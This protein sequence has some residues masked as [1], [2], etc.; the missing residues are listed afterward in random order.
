M[1]AHYF[2]KL[3]YTIMAVSFIQQP[4]SIVSGFNEMN[5]VVSSTISTTTGFKFKSKL[6]DSV[7]ATIYL[8]V[9]MAVVVVVAV[10][11]AIYVFINSPLVN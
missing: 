11:V 2:G 10:T 3:S 8:L 7:G 1:F 6:L 4:D 9:V 5:F